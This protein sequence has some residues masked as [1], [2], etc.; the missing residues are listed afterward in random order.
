MCRLFGLRYSCAAV[1]AG[2]GW[3]Q[4][5]PAG[6]GECQDRPLV[7]VD[8]GAVERSLV[9]DEVFDENRTC[10]AAEM[11]EPL[12][13]LQRLGEDGAGGGLDLVGQESEQHQHGEHGGEVQFPMATMPILSL[14]LSV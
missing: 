6:R 2:S 12:L 3:L 13:C 10:P 9:G 11:G 5:C 4:K 7:A 1:G 8:Q 14:A